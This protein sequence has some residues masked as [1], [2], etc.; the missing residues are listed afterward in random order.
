MLSAARATP[1]LRL[2]LLALFL[3]L[4]AP[5]EIHPSTRLMVVGVSAL[6]ALALL[7]DARRGGAAGPGRRA[8]PLAAAGGPGSRRALLGSL[9]VFGLVSSAVLS[10][11]PYASLH[12]LIIGSCAC[13]FFTACRR[14]ARPA[15]GWWLAGFVVAACGVALWACAQVA[16][17]MQAALE[18]GA[19]QPAGLPDLLRARLTSGRP[20]GTLL[21]PSALGGLMAMAGPVAAGLAAAGR[22]WRR[23]LPGAA[24]A[25]CA[26]VLALTRSYGALAAAAAAARWWLGRLPKHRAA[27]WRA[28]AAVVALLRALLFARARSQSTG[29]ELFSPQGPVVQ[30]LLNWETA[31]RIIGRYPLLGSGPGAYASAFVGSRRPGE[32]DTRFAHSTPLQAAAEGGAW[33]LLPLAAAA[34]WLWPR[35]RRARD[36]APAEAGAA[37]GCVAF[38]V[39]NLVDFTAYLPSTLFAGLA[40]AA[41]LPEP[42]GAGAADHGGPAA[43]RRVWAAALCAACAAGIV[44]TWRQWL[45]ESRLEEARTA[46]QREAPRPEIERLYAAALDADP[47]RVA[48]R[49]ESAAY[50]L[51]QGGAAAAQARAH[52]EAAARQDR[53][54]GEAHLLRSMAWAREGE[55][56][57]AYVA[58]RRA[59]EV[60]PHNPRA[61]AWRDHLEASLRPGAP[62]GGEP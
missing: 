21:L 54:S 16:G 53:G 15:G 29:Q 42:G 61:R 8:A 52:A 6:M 44:P 12:Q 7:D 57:E 60:H 46:R 2:L 43:A 31:A 37:T 50:L 62:P 24:A 51:E 32:N 34:A 58:A 48:L 10:L 25:L 22:G 20:F 56:A 3:S 26:G 23:A 38:A 33:T 27:A 40:L 35:V 4:W 49:L 1:Q 28:G 45:G 30:R 19:A 41:A 5:P 13:A 9:V 11:H 17:G 47:E 14:W 18:A 39:H 59:V 55:W 36:G